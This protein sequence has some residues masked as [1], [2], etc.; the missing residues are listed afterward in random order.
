MRW[1]SALQV[2]ASHCPTLVLWYFA[3]RTGTGT[4]LVMVLHWLSVFRWH[5]PGTFPTENSQSPFYSSD[6]RFQTLVQ[7]Q[8][9]R[10]DEGQVS[11]RQIEQC[12]R[13]EC[14]LQL[15]CFQTIW[16]ADAHRDIKTQFAGCTHISHI[17]NISHIS[18]T[19]WLLDAQRY[20]P[21]QNTIC[22]A[23]LSHISQAYLTYLKLFG[24]YIKTQ[25]AVRTYLTYQDRSGAL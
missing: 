10:S 5:S 22:G 23:H 25:F 3:S 19:V 17:S 21:H 1:G 2:A 15:N 20:I 18:Q 6:N 7:T 16:L 12:S 11:C 8:T 24:C 4:E 9:N 14:L 13:S